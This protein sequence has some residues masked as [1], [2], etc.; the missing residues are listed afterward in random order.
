MKRYC[1]VCEKEKEG[2]FRKDEWG[3]LECEE[4]YLG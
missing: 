3:L 1:P 4:C 2:Q